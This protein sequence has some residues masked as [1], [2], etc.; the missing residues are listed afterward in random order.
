MSR[1][2]SSV[3]PRGKSRQ[4]QTIPSPPPTASARRRKVPPSD[5]EEEQPR[6]TRMT[7]IKSTKKK[8]WSRRG[9][10]SLFAATFLLFIRV[11]RVIRGCSSS[12]AVQQK[13]RGSGGTS[14]AL[15]PLRVFPVVA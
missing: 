12:G 8:G 14:T 2:L 13:G 9:N 15:P 7:R 4:A 10:H 3:H 11:I 5:R 6:I 1:F